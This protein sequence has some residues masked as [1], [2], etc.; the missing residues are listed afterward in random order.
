MKYRAAN[1]LENFSA[2]SPAES[3]QQE[4]IQLA[5]SHPLKGHFKKLKGFCHEKIFVKALKI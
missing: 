4:N 3:G 1:T 2:R 5:E